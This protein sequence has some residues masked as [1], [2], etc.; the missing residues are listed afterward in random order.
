MRVN[1][2]NVEQIIFMDSAARRLL[3]DFK[4]LFDSWTLATKVTALRNLG[5]RSLLDFLNGLQAD[6]IKTLS[7]YF[8]EE[9]IVD[10]M[11]YHIVKNLETGL[12]EAGGE[13]SKFEG[14]LDLATYRRG[15]RLYISIWR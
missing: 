1:L 15:D 11:D 2:Q 8:R 14:F 7:E 6:H 3:P 10:K 5:K 4:H 9:V 13:L 12:D